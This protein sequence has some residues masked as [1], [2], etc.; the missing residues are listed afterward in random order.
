MAELEVVECVV[1]RSVATDEKK[2]AVP[3]LQLPSVEQVGEKR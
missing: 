3:K 2:V 1:A